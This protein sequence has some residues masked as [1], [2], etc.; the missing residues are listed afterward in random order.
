[1]SI[2]CSLAGWY[3]YSAEL[4]E[5]SRNQEE[6]RGGGSER[7]EVQDYLATGER[8]G[9]KQEEGRG[10]RRRKWRE[11]NGG[12]PG[13]RGEAEGSRKQEEGREEKVKGRKWRTTWLQG[14]GGRKQE[15]GR[16]KR[17]RK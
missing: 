3:G 9:R 10:K 12:L 2:L 13:Y 7:K 4:A 11:R 14:R 8:G 1:V 15:A 6:E 17:R 16:G 5:G